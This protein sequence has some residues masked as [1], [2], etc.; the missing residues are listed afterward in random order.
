[1]WRETLIGLKSL[2][3]GV[4]KSGDVKPVKMIKMNTSVKLE[5]TCNATPAQIWK[6]LTDKGEM[7]KWYFEI[8]DFKPEVGFEFRFWGG[9]EERKYLHI[10]VIK[11]AIEN[12][13]LC[14]TWRYDGIPGITNLC[15]EINPVNYGKTKLKLSHTGFETFP[16]DNPDLKVENFI[17][18]WSYIL[19]TSLPAYLENL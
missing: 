4:C 3:C 8:D 6:A 16:M 17:A 18:G 10:C 15:F 13:K 19:G 5:Y 11:E 9:T 12:K 1:L 2:I 7:K 14:H